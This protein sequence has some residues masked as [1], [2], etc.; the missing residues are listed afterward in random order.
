MAAILAHMCASARTHLIQ[1]VVCSSCILSGNM[2]GI[3]YTKLSSIIITHNHFYHEQLAKIMYLFTLPL[4]LPLCIQQTTCIFFINNKH[5][6]RYK[7]RYACGAGWG[8]RW[9]ICDSEG[10]IRATFLFIYKTYKYL[11]WPY[12]PY[13]LKR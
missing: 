13:L 1:H 9:V 8:P 6:V 3:H 7:Q 4:F 5:Y 10:V 2:F 12:K 11:F